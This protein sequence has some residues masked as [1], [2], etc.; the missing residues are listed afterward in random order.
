MRKRINLFLEQSAALYLKCA[1]YIF[2]MTTEKETLERAEELEVRMTETP[3]LH[4]GRS[5]TTLVHFRGV[6]LLAFAVNVIHKIFI[7]KITM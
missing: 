7:I 4:L 3:K 1:P 5:G 2:G 6:N